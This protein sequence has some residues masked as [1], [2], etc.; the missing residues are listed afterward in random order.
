[1][2]SSFLVPEPP[3]ARASRVQ[4]Q[5]LSASELLAQLRPTEDEQPGLVSA[6]CSVE[7]IPLPPKRSAWRG[8]QERWITPEEPF[9]RPRSTASH[10]PASRMPFATRQLRPNSAISLDRHRAAGIRRNV[11]TWFGTDGGEAEGIGSEHTSDAETEAEGP[12]PSPQEEGEGDAD[13]PGDAQLSLLRNWR[14]APLPGEVNSA[15][16]RCLGRLQ[17]EDEILETLVLRR[18]R[19]H[20]RVEMHNLTAALRGRRR[21]AML[22]IEKCGLG[23][24]SIDIL[25]PFLE[26]TVGRSAGLPVLE[27]LHLQGNEVSAFGVEKLCRALSSA[28]ITALN[29]HGN[30]LGDGCM[31]HIARLCAAQPRLCELDLGFCRIN[32]QGVIALARALPEVRGLRTLILD[33]NN[34]TAVS[35]IWLLDA[36][37]RNRSLTELSYRNTKAAM[38]RS[39]Q[40]EK[41][42]QDALMRNKAA[43]QRSRQLSGFG[44]N[45]GLVPKARA[46]RE[47]AGTALVVAVSSPRRVDT[48]VTFKAGNNPTRL[49]RAA[50][51][52]RR[53]V[54]AQRK[55]RASFVPFAS[56]RSSECSHS[57]GA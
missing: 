30:D 47:A 42:L 4:L 14:F 19:L 32:D 57:G 20:G 50:R 18:F 48:V 31:D 36:L 25:C 38:R 2:P 1:M 37:K 33:G 16:R 13:A 5:R 44:S 43:L 17:Q 35:G 53:E 3:S 8:A 46:S 56:R 52:A 29:L 34:I 54:A 26:E 49:C 24:A 45:A 21:L 10:R 7:Q 40:A 22:S 15:F 6:R 28:P 9:S 39:R 55:P 27:R 12:E 41:F 23:D 11:T 51:Q